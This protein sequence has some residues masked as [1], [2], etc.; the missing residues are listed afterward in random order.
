L[1]QKI[2]VDL[3]AQDA[4]QVGV[5]RSR[6]G[7]HVVI[8][9]S[10]G[11]KA[12]TLAKRG[13]IDCI[14]VESEDGFSQLG[15]MTKFLSQDLGLNQQN[16]AQYALA[17]FPDTLEKNISSLAG[18]NRFNNRQVT[19]VAIPSERQE[20]LLKG[21]ILVPHDFS[22]SYQKYAGWDYGT[23]R[24]YRDFFYNITYEAIS[25][26][27]QKWNC[28]RIGVTHFYRRRKYSTIKPYHRDL[29]TCQVEAMAHF[30]ND[31][32]G[33]ENFTFVDERGGNQSLEIVAEFNELSDVGVHRPIVTTSTQQW[34][35]DFMNL[36]LRRTKE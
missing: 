34:G 19:L 17:G 12:E 29:T 32:K 2:D 16:V 4:M 27:S 6:L 31:H 13:V 11:Q 18:W 9:Q 14:V 33:I 7:E 3:E 28:K 10:V 25:Y 1:P 21:L 8:N 22:E 35:I 36:N 26:A 15:M 30:C 20:S 23:P 5:L 24:P